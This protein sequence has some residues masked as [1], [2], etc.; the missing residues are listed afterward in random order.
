MS[1]INPN[2]RSSSSSPVSDE[3]YFIQL[4]I[5]EIQRQEDEARRIQE[6]V[7]A[8]NQATQQHNTTTVA[9]FPVVTSSSS[10]A[11]LNL[12]QSTDE[13]Y[14]LQLQMEEIARLEGQQ[15]Q[16]PTPSSTEHSTTDEDDEAF[17][18]MQLEELRRLEG[19]PV[20]VHTTPDPVMALA[21]SLGTHPIAGV[22]VPH[23]SA[24][25]ATQAF[26]AAASTA[27]QNDHG[28]ANCF[29]PV[30]DG[31]CGIS[32]LAYL[33]AYGIA[34][35]SISRDALIAK[36][37]ELNQGA[38]YSLENAL[39]D[40]NSLFTGVP[41]QRLLE[42]L[43]ITLNSITNASIYNSTI[44]ALRI[45]FAALMERAELS[46]WGGSAEEKADQ[47]RLMRNLYNEIPVNALDVLAQIL[48]ITIPIYE[49]NELYRSEDNATGIHTPAHRDALFGRASTTGTN[50]QNA[51]ILLLGGHYMVLTK[52][53]ATVVTEEETVVE[54][55]VQ[56]TSIEE[57]R[58]LALE[59]VAYMQSQA[60]RQAQQEQEEQE[61]IEQ[62]QQERMEEQRR[63]EQ[64]EQRNQATRRAAQRARILA[65]LERRQSGNN[66]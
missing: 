25:E 50:A 29:N 60:Q 33:L 34:S 13:A 16:A 24:N 63:L 46:L 7:E 14:L 48:E 53:E 57:R 38:A 18:Q 27:L 43:E 61:R 64:E 26:Y 45:V 59:G 20:E 28:Y 23:A 10:N 58:R 1:D 30:G 17:F 52:V 15:G 65:A 56:P 62:Q 42:H 2:A 5:A 54:E 51:A 35:G 44:N 66:S 22:L 3:E 36:F 9:N 11:G 6:Q 37:N 55:T 41:E 32:A 47:I 39:Y 12:P 4:Q 8:I 31:N 19:F 49:V 40:T 21:G